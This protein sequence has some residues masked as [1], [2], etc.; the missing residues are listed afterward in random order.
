[1][2]AVRWHGV[3]AMIDVDSVDGRR[4]ARDGWVDP[5]PPPLALFVVDPLILVGTIDVVDV[6]VD[7]A[8]GFPGPY[9]YG[10]GTVGGPDRIHSDANVIARTF[11]DGESYAVAISVDRTEWDEPES[12]DTGVLLVRRWRV[13]SA[14]LTDAPAWPEARIARMPS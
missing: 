14:T 4:L 2:T 13:V 9:V 3:L 8:F 10:E 11:D 7:A 12:L 5:L 1:M 6:R